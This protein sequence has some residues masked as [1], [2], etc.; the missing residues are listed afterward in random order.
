MADPVLKAG[1]M[2]RVTGS[3]M[4][5]ACTRFVQVCLLYTCFVSPF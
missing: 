2:S 4:A 1:S 3:D 5:D